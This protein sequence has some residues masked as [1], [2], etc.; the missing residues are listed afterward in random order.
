[1]AR[2]PNLYLDTSMAFSP[3][4]AKY[5]GIEPISSEQLIRWQDRICFGSDF[6]IIPYDYEEEVR[7]VLDRKLPAE[8]ERKIFS[9]N[10]L[11]FLGL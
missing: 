9:V 6:P 11:R 10:A 8:V 5:V 4:V 1:M 7:G 2:C 3:L